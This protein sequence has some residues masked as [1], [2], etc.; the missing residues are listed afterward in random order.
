[1]DL[2]RLGKDIPN[3]G[4]PHFISL[5]SYCNFLFLKEIYSW[6]VTCIEQI[7]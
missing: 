3:I 7:Y 2:G 6:L 5:H 1:M 4:I